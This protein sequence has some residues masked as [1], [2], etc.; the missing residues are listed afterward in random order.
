MDGE[1]M[2]LFDVPEKMVLRHPSPAAIEGI[3]RAVANAERE[4]KQWSEGALAY[5][6]HF[7]RKKTP[8]TAPET[9]KYAEAMGFP[10][11]PNERSWGGPFLAASNR[12]LIVKTGNPRYAENDMH[13]Q[14]IQEWIGT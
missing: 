13:G 5:V 2:D 14:P 10:R 7:A 1:T 3:E 4:R 12:G 9:R 6:I 11:P 8:F